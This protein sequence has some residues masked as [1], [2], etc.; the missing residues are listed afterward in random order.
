MAAIG[1]MVL[2][3]RAARAD[4]QET[5]GGGVPSL[6]AVDDAACQ[7]IEGWVIRIGAVVVPV[8]LGLA[9]TDREARVARINERNRSKI[10][11]ERRRR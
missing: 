11:A 7:N 10:E 5:R 9:D 2:G 1:G 3:A 8:A 4:E 6:C